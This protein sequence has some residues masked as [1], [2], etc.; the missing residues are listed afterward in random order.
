MG[1]PQPL[2]GPELE[3]AL[4]Q[5]GSADGPTV[6]RAA[7]LLSGQRE[8]TSRLLPLL[9][10]ERRPANRQ[11]ILY[12]L[13]WQGD[14]SLWET[15]IQVLSD[16]NEAPDVRGQAAEGLE[17]LF[18]EV[19]PGTARFEAGVSA[20]VGA[21]HDPS[22]EVR[23]CSALALGSTGH[24]PLVPTIAQLLSDDARGTSFHGGEKDAAEEAIDDLRRTNEH[25]TRTAGS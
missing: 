7:T 9:A 25:R 17:Y 18:S 14:L 3:A 11:G 12:A 10:D 19:D 22:P 2:S 20:L 1:P 13:A 6:I 8:L 21:L 15:F 16:T 23:G 4:A 5:L 24:L